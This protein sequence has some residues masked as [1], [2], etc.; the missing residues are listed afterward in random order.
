MNRDRDGT[1]FG[2]W[3]TVT[4]G[5]RGRIAVP[6]VSLE[7]VKKPPLRGRI[8]RSRRS[9]DETIT[10]AAIRENLDVNYSRVVN[11]TVRGHKYVLVAGEYADISGLLTM[12]LSDAGLRQRPTELIY[13]KHRPPPWLSEDATRDR[14]SR[15]LDG[16]RRRACYH[17]C[18]HRS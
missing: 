10:C 14:S 3:F 15:L 2:C 13:P 9:D 16:V 8:A 7:F 12:R 1:G 17:H 5:V 4:A 6:D 18:H 11:R